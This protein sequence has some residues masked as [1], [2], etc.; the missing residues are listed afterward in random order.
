MIERIVLNVYL[1][2]QTLFSVGTGFRRGLLGSDVIIVRDEVTGLP[3][4]PG[5]TLK[6]IIRKIVA[7]IVPNSCSSVATMSIDEPLVCGVA[8]EEA[9][10]LSQEI[11]P[12]CRCFGT[13]HVP[14]YII[15]EDAHVVDEHREHLL[16]LASQEA[17]YTHISISRFLDAVERGKLWTCE[18]VPVGTLF[19]TRILCLDPDECLK[20]LLVGLSLLSY[21]HAGRGGNLKVEKVEVIEGLNYVKRVVTELGLA[22]LLNVQ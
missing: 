10:S 15:V 4:I 17:Q 14:G 11:C 1:R 16:K 20:M 21:E 12:V 3:Y 13:P 8:I 7:Q 19:R 18:Y 9:G 2:T 22:E 6:G 5:T